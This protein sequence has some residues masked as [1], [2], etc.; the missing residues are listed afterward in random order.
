MSNRKRGFVLT[1][2]V[3]ISIAVVGFI[4][5]AILQLKDTDVFPEL[6]SKRLASDIIAVLDYNGILDTYDKTK[7]EAN[8]SQLLPAN[9]NMSM[10]IKRFNS[11]TFLSQMQINANITEN[12]LAGKWWLVSVNST[13]QSFY[14]VEYRVKF[15]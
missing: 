5:L 7:I 13:N 12:F 14:L 4:L 8:L 2:D 1:M 10:I 9:L 11:T 3:A 15:K 6:E